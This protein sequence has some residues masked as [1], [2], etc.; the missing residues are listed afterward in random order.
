M[1]WK[2]EDESLVTLMPSIYAMIPSAFLLIMYN[3]EKRRTEIR[4]SA[5]PKVSYLLSMLIYLEEPREFQRDD[6]ADYEG[7]FAD[8]SLPMSCEPLCHGR[9]GP[10]A[11]GLFIQLLAQVPM[12]VV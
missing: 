7:N 10:C 11:E 5:R 6:H 9:L 8:P 1:V 4:T 3:D 12:N 2:S